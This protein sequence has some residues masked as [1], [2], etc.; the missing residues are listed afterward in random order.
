MHDE[1]LQRK[2]AVNEGLL[3]EANEAIERGV[4][5][6]DQSRLI[7]FRCECA[8]VECNQVVELRVS[9]YEEVRAHPRRFFVVRGHERAGVESVLESRPGYNIVEKA[10]EGGRVAEQSDPRS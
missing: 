8:E 6:G 3:R 7:R 9:E 2:I 4:W 10:G 1:A 5:P